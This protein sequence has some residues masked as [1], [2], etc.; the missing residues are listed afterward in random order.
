MVNK[1]IP[2]FFNRKPVEDKIDAS[3]ERKEVGL[4][5]RCSRHVLRPES[6]WDDFETAPR[7]PD[8]NELLEI[9][10]DANG[11][12]PEEETYEEAERFRC[13]VCRTLMISANRGPYC[14]LPRC[15]EIWEAIKSGIAE[16]YG[17]QSKRAFNCNIADLHIMVY[18]PMKTRVGFI[19]K[20]VAYSTYLDG[21]AGWSAF[22]VVVECREPHIPAEVDE[23]VSIRVP[24]LK[25]LGIEYYY[26]VFRRRAGRDDQEDLQTA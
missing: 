20:V 23:L 15:K 3:E 7:C 22:E 10:L 14:I 5:P 13:V 8:C 18:D 17:V 21:K 12:L 4:C 19:G 25:K 1:S 2:I 9:D 26:P 16:R 11:K 24:S 6:A